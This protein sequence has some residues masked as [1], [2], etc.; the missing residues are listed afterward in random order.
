MTARRRLPAG[1]VLARSRRSASATGARPATSSR[2]TR[3]PAAAPAPSSSP[4]WPTATTAAGRAA[5]TASRPR[6]WPTSACSAA[7][8]RWR[9]S[10]PGSSRRRALPAC[11]LG[12]GGAPPP[13]SDVDDRA[14]S[15][16]RAGAAPSSFGIQSATDWTWFVPGLTFAA[17][18]AAGFVA[19]RGPLT[20]SRRP[21]A[22]RP[23]VGAGLACASV[24]ALALICGWS[25]WQPERVGARERPRPG[26]AGRGQD[27]RG[28]RSRPAARATSTRIR[29][30]RCYPRRDARPRGGRTDALPDLEQAV[31]EHPRDP[32]TWL[33]LG[34]SSWTSW[35]CPTGRSRPRWAPSAWI[36]TRA[37]ANTAEASAL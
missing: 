9:C 12:A 22:S 15:A 8:R 34:R 7:R 21:A 14:R 29:R 28:R 33:R 1:A 20:G 30:T 16:R 18:L 2:R 11:C 19:G 31:L 10:S 27:R 13:G 23:H 26:A 32:E 4:V 3:S 25:I 35:T 5:P 17:L 24:L 37:E 6:P 36:P